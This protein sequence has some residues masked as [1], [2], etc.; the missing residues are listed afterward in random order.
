MS[1][2]I[3]RRRPFTD[4]QNQHT[5]GLKT[6]G[7]SVEHRVAIPIGQQV[8]EDTAAQNRVVSLGSAGED[9]ADRER[10]HACWLAERRV[11]NFH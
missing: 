8:I 4:I 7:E 1:F 5:A 3:R 6:A 10:E 2:A 9:I 11:G